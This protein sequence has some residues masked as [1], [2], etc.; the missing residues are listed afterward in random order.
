MLKKKQRSN[1]KNHSRNATFYLHK[2]LNI[3]LPIGL[4]LLV[5]AGLVELS[6]LIAL[7]SKWRVFAVKP[8]HLIANLRSN[9]TDIIV[10]IS[11]ISFIV[12]A[13]TLNEQLIWTG[14]YIIW[15]AVIKPSS[16]KGLVTFQAAAGHLLGVSAV[17]LFSNN[18]SDLAILFLIWVVALSSARHFFS[19]YEEPKTQLMSQLWAFFVLQMAW[20]LNK[21]LLVYVLVPQ[22]IFIIGV[23]GYAVASIYDAQARDS[24]KQSFV[25]QQAGMTILILILILI[26]ADWQ[27]SI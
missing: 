16:T 2:L 24:L 4:L 3:A 27:G 17:F 13:D 5:R 14:W 11:T 7:F 12:Q 6:I 26:L 18:I 22:L 10:K 15:L 8:R 25:R 9:A 21:W 20:V 23:I 19:S 1:D